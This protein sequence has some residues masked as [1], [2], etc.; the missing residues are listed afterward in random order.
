MVYYLGNES[1]AVSWLSAL[2][3]EAAL[4]SPSYADL[5]DHILAML[6]VYCEHLVI[7]FM[8]KSIRH[9]N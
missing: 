2:N 7:V 8:D 9:L 4:Q 5:Y 3:A 1:T 6:D